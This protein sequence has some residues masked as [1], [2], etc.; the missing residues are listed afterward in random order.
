ML[1][2]G[3]TPFALFF[4]PVGA[5]GVNRTPWRGVR[6]K[7][8][9]RT[10]RFR[11]RERE[12]ERQAGSWTPWRGVR[13]KVELAAGRDGNGKFLA[14]AFGGEFFDF[15]VTGNRLNF[16][17]GRVL[18]DRM[19]ATFANQGTAVGLQVGEEIDPLHAGMVS[20]FSPRRTDF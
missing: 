19:A 10:F 5:G 1:F 6:T 11:E 4:R 15:P 9:G 8:G 17:V 7:R 18:P 12:G 3:L 16:L 13:T 14:D 20:S 2:P